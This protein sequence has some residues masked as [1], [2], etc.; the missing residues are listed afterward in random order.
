M[1][2]VGVFIIILNFGYYLHQYYIHGP[3]DYAL[4]WQYGHELVVNT[5]KTIQPKYNK[6]IVSTSLDEPY[7]FFLYYLR[8]DPAKYLSFGGTKSGKFDEERNAFDKYEFHTY[9]NTPVEGKSNVLY[10]GTPE[11]VLTGAHHEADIKDPSGN[12]VYVISSIN[13]G[14]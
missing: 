7:M 1:L 6:V 11:E 5:V 9:M 13:S 3:I 12:I 2:S 10:V 4:E 14:K 8:Y